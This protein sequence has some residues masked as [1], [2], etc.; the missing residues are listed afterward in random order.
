MREDK[1][2]YENGA[3]PKL[4][5]NPLNDKKK[6]KRMQGF[7]FCIEYTS[8][9]DDELEWRVWLLSNPD[10]SSSATTPKTTRASTRTLPHKCLIAKK[11]KGIFLQRANLGV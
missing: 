6:N 4:K 5:P 1:P 11:T 9:N 8:D 2:K 10:H 7:F 3:M